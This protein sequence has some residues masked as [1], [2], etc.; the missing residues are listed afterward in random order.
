MLL[1]CEDELISTLRWLVTFFR[2]GEPLLEMILEDK[3]CMPPFVV[4][5]T[6]GNPSSQMKQMSEPVR[7]RQSR[8]R[9]H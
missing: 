4:G 1:Y 6:T 2:P 5:L 3:S 8:P 9:N 7:I